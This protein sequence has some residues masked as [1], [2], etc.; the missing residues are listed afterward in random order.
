ML[1][2]GLESVRFLACSSAVQVYI[3]NLLQLVTGCGGGGG[4]GGG[5]GS[6]V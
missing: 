1:G 2:M 3:L 4:G 6:G 5:G